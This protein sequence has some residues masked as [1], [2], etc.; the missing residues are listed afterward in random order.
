MSF[1][2]TLRDLIES[3]DITQKQ[4]SL[5]L[6]LAASTIGSY[7]QNVREP[8]FETLK[9]IASYFHV[10]IDYLLDYRSERA[11]THAEDELLCIFRSLT[12]DQQELY[13]EQGKVMVKLNSKKSA[14]SL[15]STS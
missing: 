10:S 8:D 5:D 13:L 3:R 2:E 12:I 15:K 11:D 4:L 9:R 7:V 14:E 6:H 1:G